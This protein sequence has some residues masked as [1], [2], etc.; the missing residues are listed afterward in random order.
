M[1]SYRNAPV[2]PDKNLGTADSLL[3]GTVTADPDTGSFTKRR[4]PSPPRPNA[5]ANNASPLSRNR[6]EH[7]WATPVAIKNIN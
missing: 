1:Y 3:R 5:R 7:V 4:P 6:D 2:I